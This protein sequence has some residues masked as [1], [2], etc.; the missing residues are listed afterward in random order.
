MYDL[1]APYFWFLTY[2][3]YNNAIIK[4]LNNIYTYVESR[5]IIYSAT[6]FNYEI[7]NETIANKSLI[8]LVSVYFIFIFRICF[9]LILI[10]FTG[11]TNKFI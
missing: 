5:N 2:S 6:K 11:F 8:F 9:E 1:V 4:S 7:E 3:T 10:Y